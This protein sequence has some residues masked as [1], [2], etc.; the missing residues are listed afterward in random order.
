MLRSRSHDAG[1]S[2]VQ[3]RPKT[4]ITNSFNENSPLPV[5]AANG[6]PPGFYVPPRSLVPLAPSF[7]N[8]TPIRRKRTTDIYF[9]FKFPLA[10]PTNITF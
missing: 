6:H 3:T 5:E 8:V 4:L 1:N 7:S 2:G 10:I 9:L